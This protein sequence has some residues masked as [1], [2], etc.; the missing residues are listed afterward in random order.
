MV[1]QK[2]IDIN[3]RDYR[4]RARPNLH[5]GAGQRHGFG[6]ELR[7][8]HH[9]QCT[10]NG[11]QDDQTLGSRIEILAT[12]FDGNVTVCDPV[13]IDVLRSGGPPAGYTYT[14]LRGDEGIVRIDNGAQG[15]RSS[16]SR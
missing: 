1:H 6:P 9:G 2:Q 15:S 11:H 3:V 14:G 13:L 7:P 5:L 4:L 8:E 10:G 16:K 12:D